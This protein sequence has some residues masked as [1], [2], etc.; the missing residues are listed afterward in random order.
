MLPHSGFLS[1]TTLQPPTI[2]SVPPRAAQHELIN[3]SNTPQFS[4]QPINFANTDKTHS[5]ELPQPAQN[6][7]NISDTAQ[8]ISLIFDTSDPL[9]SQFSSPT[10]SQF[11]SNPFNPPQGPISNIER[12]ISQALWNDSFNI[13]NSSPSFQNS[14]PL[15]FQI[16]T[17]IIQLSSN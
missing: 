17:P 16:T 13:V 6:I 1:N 11:A 15:S 8:D 7:S 10:P 2:I 9:S 12:F 4:T 14:L 3:Y 5:S